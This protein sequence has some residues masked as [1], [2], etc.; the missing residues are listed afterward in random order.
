MRPPYSAPKPP[1]GLEDGV[2]ADGV[3]G[4]VDNHA[5]EQAEVLYHRTSA[6]VQLAALVAGGTH[7]G[8]HLHV[9]RQVGDASDGGHLLYLRRGDFLHAHLC[10]HLPFLLL[11]VHNLHS[12]QQ[13]CCR[14]QVDGLR[15]GAALLERNLLAVFLIAHVAHLQGVGALLHLVDQEETVD[16][17]G[18]AMR[19]A[20]EHH[21]GK[22]NGLAVALVEQHSL[23]S[24][25]GTG[26]DGDGY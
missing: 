26:D 14:L 12:L 17:R 2:E 5:V 16:V 1:V 11:A 3:E 10:L 4:V 6:D 19:R 7:T 22:R 9:L 25:L 15:D 23:H 21:V 18:A 20:V 24:A 13:L 8:Q